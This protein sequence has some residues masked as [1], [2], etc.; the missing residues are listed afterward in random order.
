MAMLDMSGFYDMNGKCP[1]PDKHPISAMYG[2]RPSKSACQ[3]MFPSMD[4][5]QQTLITPL[6]LSSYTIYSNNN[7]YSHTSLRV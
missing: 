2:K 6:A 7:N 3:R 4:T 5:F 1:L